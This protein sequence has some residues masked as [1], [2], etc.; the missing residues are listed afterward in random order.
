VLLPDKKKLNGSRA[1]G[2]P[3]ILREQC[4]KVLRSMAS[5][6]SGEARGGVRFLLLGL[7]VGARDFVQVLSAIPDREDCLAVN[8]REATP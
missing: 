7:A 3:E 2:K 6:R 4:R 1:H 5:R 8:A